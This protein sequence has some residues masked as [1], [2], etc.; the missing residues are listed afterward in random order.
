[1]V[2]LVKKEFIAFAEHHFYSLRVV[3]TTR[4]VIS[5]FSVAIIQYFNYCIWQRATTLKHFFLFQSREI[6]TKIDGYNALSFLFV[7]NR[8]VVRDEITHRLQAAWI[9]E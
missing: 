8:V 2:R 7:F 1:M 5:L 3:S 6:T 9:A 4:E